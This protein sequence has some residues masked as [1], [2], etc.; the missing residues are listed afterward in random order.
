[1]LSITTAASLSLVLVAPPAAVRCPP[2]ARA[3]LLFME[4]AEEP[5][6]PPPAP[7]P[8][9]DTNYYTMGYKL[10]GAP[11]GTEPPYYNGN[12]MRERMIDY[13]NRSPGMANIGCYATFRPEMIA[14]FNEAMKDGD[15]KMMDDERVVD[16]N[17]LARMGAGGA[18]TP[19][20]E[21]PLE[22]LMKITGEELEEAELNKLL[23]YVAYPAGKKVAFEKWSKIMMDAAQ[24]KVA[25]EKGEEKKTG[26]FGLF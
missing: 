11:F 19:K 1:M 24:G 4:E 23:E 15:P 6:A 18:A 21:V 10:E 25:E 3:G 13:I 8:P 20:G 12:N 22:A 9:P 17:P 5:N 2:A 16:E 26:F 7:P 14:V